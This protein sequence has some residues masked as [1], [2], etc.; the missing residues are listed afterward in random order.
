MA[1]GVLGTERDCVEY[2][3]G[4][5]GRL[6]ICLQGG[7]YHKQ[8]NVGVTELFAAP[9]GMAVLRNDLHSMHRTGLGEDILRASNR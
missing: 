3:C 2:R 7:T 6:V 9:D 5:L 8:G 4:E 1:V